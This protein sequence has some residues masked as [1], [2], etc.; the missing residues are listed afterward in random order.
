MRWR[1]RSGSGNVDDRRGMSIGGL[2]TGGGVIGVILYLIVS[3]MGGDPSQLPINPG[4]QAGQEQR[5]ST[6][7]EDTLVQFVSVVLAETEK[8]WADIFANEGIRY[9]PPV[10]VLYTDLVQSGCGRAGANTGPFYCPADQK[11]YIDL[12][13][14]QELRN[15]FGAP[16]DFAMAYVIA[17]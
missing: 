11:L 5:A 12:S 4:T 16:G 9:Q 7:E 14:Y 1:G 6:A 2:A 15:R 3:L 8:T 17:H 13:F 10:L